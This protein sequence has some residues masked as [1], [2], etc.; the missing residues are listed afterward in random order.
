MGSHGC[1]EAISEFYLEGE[2]ELVVRD[3]EVRMDAAARDVGDGK[4]VGGRDDDAAHRGGE[5]DEGEVEVGREDLGQVLVPLGLRLE[6][7]GDVGVREERAVPCLK[8]SE[9]RRGEQP[10][11]HDVSLVTKLPP[12]R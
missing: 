4:G 9:E 3:V 7:G 1:G 6:G 8:E 11:Q 12:H 5:R 10:A 2:R